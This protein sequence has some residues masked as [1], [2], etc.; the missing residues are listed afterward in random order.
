MRT[1]RLCAEAPNRP[2]NIGV[3]EFDP[4]QH[5]GDDGPHPDERQSAAN[6]AA[7]QINDGS[8]RVNAMIKSL[9]SKRQ[10]D[11]PFDCG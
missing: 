4:G 9:K 1:I 11:H 5:Q 8:R 3:R 10:V 2:H 6:D 7:S